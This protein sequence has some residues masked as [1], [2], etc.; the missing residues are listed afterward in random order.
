MSAPP[1]AAANLK[2]LGAATA[3]IIKEQMAQLAVGDSRLTELKVT[4]VK[5]LLAEPG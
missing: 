1:A 3:A 5:A 4:S 2:T